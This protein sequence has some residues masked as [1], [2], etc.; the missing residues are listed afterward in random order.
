MRIGGT[1]RARAGVAG[2][3]VGDRES[4]PGCGC[5]EG[6]GGRRGGGGH[7]GPHRPA[8]S[9]R[10]LAEEAAGVAETDRSEVMG[11]LALCNE[12]YLTTVRVRLIL[13]SCEPRS[14]PFFSSLSDS[15][16]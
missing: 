12:K 3:H 11:R 16:G 13:T 15:T 7:H 4:V 10:G 2:D 14:S 6:G 9:S 1:A 5:A 8:Q